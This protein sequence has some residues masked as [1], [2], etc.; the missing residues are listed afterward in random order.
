MKA[1]RS[2]RPVELKRLERK[3]VHASLQAP[4]VRVTGYDTIMPYYRN[5]AHYLPKIED[6]VQAVEEVISL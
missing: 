1:R 3:R 5:E 4:V 6:I 2:R